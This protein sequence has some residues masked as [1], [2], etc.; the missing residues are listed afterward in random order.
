MARQRLRESCLR[1]FQRRVEE[2]DLI[3]VAAQAGRREQG[4]QRR[5]RLHLA[6]LFAVVVEVVGMGEKDVYHG[7]VP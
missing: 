7:L 4:L 3:P 5:I 2:R 6:H 1:R